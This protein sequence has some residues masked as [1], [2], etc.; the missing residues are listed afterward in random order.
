MRNNISALAAVIVLF[1]AALYIALPVDHPAWLEN[2]MASGEESRDLR[3]LTLGLDLEGGTQ[4]L[5]EADLPADE[6]VDPEAMRSARVIVEQRVNGLGVTEPLVQA[7]G[8]RRIVVELPGISNPE[9]AINTLRATGQL[10][11]VD[12]AGAQM[13]GGMVINTS[14]HPEAVSRLQEATA[15]G[16][17]TPQLTPY[18]Q[19][20]ET[21]M[22]GD[23]L[24]TALATQDQFG[25]WQIQFDL[26]AEG[27]ELFYE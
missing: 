9:Q 15:E 24:R 6:E 12:P 25:Q 16:E 5:L 13:A 11:F 4:V 23:I 8:D 1:L 10:E 27:S 7:Q 26:T 2:G 18:E 19:V 20:F 22:T 3:N 14:N 21:V 17:S